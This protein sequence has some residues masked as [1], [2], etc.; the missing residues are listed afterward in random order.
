M[1]L[2][3]FQRKIKTVAIRRLERKYAIDF[4]KLNPRNW[5]FE[6]K[7]FES[8]LWKQKGKPRRIN[9]Q[10]KQKYVDQLTPPQ[11]DEIWRQSIP[12][13]RNPTLFQRFINWLIPIPKNISLHA[14]KDNWEKEDDEL[15]EE[16]ADWNDG[17]FEGI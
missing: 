9:K 5:C 4:S 8:P 13:P 15:V 12:K 14:E 16:G 10:I 6:G 3:R 17:E 2:A 1:Y 7:T 11:E